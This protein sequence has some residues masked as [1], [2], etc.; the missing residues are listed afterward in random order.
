MLS[1]PV[2]FAYL[3]VSTSSN[4][5]AWRDSLAL[6][7]KKCFTRRQ[8]LVERWVNDNTER[9]KDEQLAV[10][11]RASVNVAQANTMEF[12]CSSI[13]KEVSCITVLDHRLSTVSLFVCP[14]QQPQRTSQL[15]RRS[16]VLRTVFSVHREEH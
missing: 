11:L 7:V 10:A 15:P 2:L 4:H 5:A 12:V 16:Q 13:C 1:Q 6:L 3:I 9:F 14:S 8:L